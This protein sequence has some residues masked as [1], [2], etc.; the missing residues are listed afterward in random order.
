MTGLSNWGRWGLDDELG[1]LN[2]ISDEVRARAVMQATTGR[3]ISLAVPIIP[4][5][6]SGAFGAAAHRMPA[7]VAQ[8][9]TYTD[10]RAVAF[11]DILTINV[12]HHDSTHIDALAHVN[13]DGKVYP[14]ILVDD[15][16][17]GGT[18]R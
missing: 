3:V 15:A 10:S 13:C 5:P 16:I 2:F 14:G 8:T 1:T 6:M 4:V 11:T 12:H 9:L 7:A 17:A 18:V